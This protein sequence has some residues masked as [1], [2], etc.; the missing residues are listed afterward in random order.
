MEETKQ[1]KKKMGRP[2]KVIIVDKKEERNCE[3]EVET[4]LSIA[5]KI[6]KME[7]DIQHLKDEFYNRVVI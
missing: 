6:V 4:L 3:S 5:K 2:K 1:Y 7:D